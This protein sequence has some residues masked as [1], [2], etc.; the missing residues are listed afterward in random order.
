MHKTQIELARRF[1]HVF[2]GDGTYCTNSH[3]MPLYHFV[4][5]NA[6]NRTLSLCFVFM[7]KN[8]IKQHDY[9]WVFRYFKYYVF[10]HNLESLSSPAYEDIWCVISCSHKHR[11]SYH[12]SSDQVVLLN[13]L[14]TVHRNTSQISYARQLVCLLSGY[15]IVSTQH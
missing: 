6:Q 15:L 1:P 7:K 9:E 5:I 11:S 8:E 2:M 3:D 13:L 10:Y 4:G 12:S 14:T